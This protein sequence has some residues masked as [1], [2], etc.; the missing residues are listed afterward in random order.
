MSKEIV[1]WR[2][3]TKPSIVEIESI[4]SIESYW[5]NLGGFNEQNYCMQNQGPKY[6]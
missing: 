2:F 4:E 5:Q 6:D 3:N 1:N